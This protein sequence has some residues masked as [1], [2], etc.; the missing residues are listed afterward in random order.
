MS[1][2]YKKSVSSLCDLNT[3]G[4]KSSVRSY[5][6]LAS[7]FCCKLLYFVLSVSYN[8][9]TLLKSNRFHLITPTGEKIMA[10]SF[11]WLKAQEREA[12]SYAQPAQCANNVSR[13]Y[14]NADIYRYSSPLVDNVVDA[15][16]AR[17]GMVVSLPKDPAG[18]ARKLKGLW[19]GRIPAG[20]FISGCLNEDCSGNAGDGHISIVGNIDTSGRVQIYHNNWYRPDNEGGQWKEHMIPLSWYNSGFLR[21]WMPTPWIYIQRYATSG[22]P[23]TIQSSLPAIDDLDPANYYVKISI[24]VEI[25]NE[26][27]SGKAVMT[28]GKGAIKAYADGSGSGH[29]NNTDSTISDLG[30]A[31]AWNSTI[32]KLQPADSST[33]VSSQKCSVPA[34]TTVGYKAKRQVGTHWELTLDIPDSAACP[35]AAFGMNAKVFVYAPHFNLIE[36]R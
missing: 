33:L 2:N 31:V 10:S 11:A 8:R 6:C 29:E 9:D 19:G 16:A 36:P 12:G 15:V 23:T 34:G 24:P 1:L 18:I 4:F 22:T 35:G 3:L 27:K 30:K 7:I 25:L 32:L 26:I 14:E 17:G 28:D 21:K 20:S 13:V 5:A